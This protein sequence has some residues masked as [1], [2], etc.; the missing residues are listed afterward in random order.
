MVPRAIQHVFREID[1]DKDKHV[2]VSVSF[3]E[4]YNEEMY[5]LLSDRPGNSDDLVVVTE[6]NS[7]TVGQH[8]GWQRYTF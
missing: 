5:D 7:V 1:N 4:I 3:L 8:L 2:D 6:N